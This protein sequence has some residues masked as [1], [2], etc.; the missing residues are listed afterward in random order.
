MSER[1]IPRD[2][3]LADLRP[4][5]FDHLVIF[6]LLR[7][8]RK[9]QLLVVVEEDVLQIRVIRR[10]RIL[11]QK[12]HTCSTTCT[13]DRDQHGCELQRAEKEGNNAIPSEKRWG[14]VGATDSVVLRRRLWG[15]SM[16]LPRPSNGG[17]RTRVAWGNAAAVKIR[18]GSSRAAR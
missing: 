1:A 11:L 4:R 14:R 2:A 13:N 6:E 18:R 12:R 8:D 9:E 16:Q 3:Y 15:A 17:E 7:G 5:P 10:R